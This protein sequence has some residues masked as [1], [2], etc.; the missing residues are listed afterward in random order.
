M[1]AFRTMVAKMVPNLM[2]CYG[3][4]WSKGFQSVYFNLG[5]IKLKSL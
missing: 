1:E 2:L 5:A 3:S 4:Q